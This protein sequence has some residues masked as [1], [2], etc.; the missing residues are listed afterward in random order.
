M[1]R[2]TR[3][4]WGSSP[5]TQEKL[6]F[7]ERLRLT[8]DVRLAL[9]LA[10]ESAPKHLLSIGPLKIVGGLLPLASLYL[11]KLVVDALS[12][13]LSSPHPVEHFAR[14]VFLIIA[15]GAVGILG[16][17]LGGISG[18]IGQAQ[19]MLVGD[20][21]QSLIQQKSLDLD[22]EFYEDPQYYDTLQRARQDGGNLPVRIVQNITSLAQG[23]VNLIAMLGLL[24][25]FSPLMVGVLVIAAI[26]SVIV[27][28]KYT[29]IRYQWQRDRTERNRLLGS[30]DGMISGSYFAKEVRLY[31]LGAL[32]RERWMRLR[33][34][35]RGE[36]IELARRQTMTGFVAQ[37]AGAAI[38]FVGV[39][40]MA[41]NALV[42]G[43]TLGSLAMYYQAFQR[44]LSTLRSLMMEVADLYEGNLFLTNLQEFFRQERRVT[45]P[46]NPRP[47]ARPIREGIRFESVSFRYPRCE[48]LVLRDVS[49]KLAPDEVVAIVGENGSGKTTMMKLLCRLYNPTEGRILLDG[50][51]LREY[52]SRDLRR[53]I[54]VIF[55]DFAKYP[56]TARENIWIGDLTKDPSS[57][58]IEAAARLAGIHHDLAKLPKGYDTLL[59]RWFTDGEELSIGQWQKI[60]LARAFLRDSQ[61]IVLDEPTSSMDARSEYEVFLHFRE[62]LKGRS[63]IIV[64]HRFSTVRLADR[65][66]VVEEGRVIEEGSHETLVARDGVYAKMYSL[67][68]AAFR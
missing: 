28:L 33:K 62:L 54:G 40:F 11:T 25:S 34:E 22:L 27:K 9:R 53:E 56:V 36:S 38:V 16:S 58:A 12:V 31:D 44:G 61:I 2:P 35:L 46:A 66:Y 65:I 8:F 24:L 51:D 55:Q 26:P 21:V 19:G 1:A 7:R 3:F 60:A 30:Y 13:A 64:S 39:L 10:W 18:L 23:V 57:D 29:D 41:R 43:I 32:L 50:H 6:S 52:A 37:T 48:K 47:I 42:G 67:Q 15:A 59:A 4:T 17:V 20:H 68:A 45:E 5:T 63:A 14:V 49:L